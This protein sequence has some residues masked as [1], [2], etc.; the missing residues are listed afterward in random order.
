MFSLSP[1]FGAVKL[2][3]LVRR[4]VWL[5]PAAVLATSHAQ[6]TYST[7]Y[8]FTHLAGPLGG[9]GNIDGVGTAARFYAPMSLA[10]DG[11]GN[12]YVADVLNFAIRKVT[13][14]GKVTTLD[15]SGGI[16]SSSIRGYVAGVAVDS[17]NNVYITDVDSGQ[18]LRWTTTGFF[19]PVVDA[20]PGRLA[21][22][23]TGTTYIA[24]DVDN[25]VLKIVPGASATV[26]AGTPS[27]Y[28]SADGAGAAAR[29]LSVR[30]VAVDGTGTLYVADSSN[31]TIRKITPAGDVTTFSGIAGQPGSLDGAGTAARFND[32][33]GLAVDDG[34]NVYVADSFNDT[35]RKIS[36]AGDVTTLAGVA[37]QAGS[38]DGIGAAARFYGPSD[39]A[40]DHSGNVYVADV[41]NETI[42]KIAVDG[43]VG[44]L[45]GLAGGS[46]Y[47]E[48]QATF[49]RFNFSGG[50]P[51]HVGITADQSGTAYVSDTFNHCIRKISPDGK[52][53]ILAGSPG[54]AGS[55]DGSGS[56]ARF[57]Q[58]EGITID[59]AG[60]LFVTDTG[61]ST[62]RKITPDGVVTTVAGVPGDVGSTDGIGTAA[63]FDHPS[64]LSTGA[65]GE[66]FVTDTRNNS[67]R[68][69]SAGGA[70][71]TIA[72]KAGSG[73]FQTT[74]GDTYG[75]GGYRDG[76][77]ADA[78]FS[79]PSDITTDQT[80]N[81]Y[82][83]DSYTALVRKI[84]PEGVVTTVAGNVMLAP[85]SMDGPGTSAQFNEP[86]SLARDAV[87]NIYI[88][89]SGNDL[90]RRISADGNVSTIGGVHGMVSSADGMGRDALFNSPRGVAL[91]AAG[92][93]YVTDAGN[94]AVRKG[95]LAGAPAISVQPQ[96]Q[97]VRSGGSAQFAV[98]ADG[99]PPPAYQWFFGGKQIAGATNATFNLSSVA[100]GSAGDYTVVVTNSL[101]SVTSAKATLLIQSDQISA[102]PASDGAAGGG[103]FG[104]GFTLLLLTLGASYQPLRRRVAYSSRN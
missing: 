18:V 67:V 81:L 66:I 40:V 77:G 47:R 3:R 52:T 24:N 73:S 85:G 41:A 64:G 39:I 96:S 34:G 20:F 6:S 45:A 4:L 21:I 94:N 13:P 72:G 17:A 86:V 26:L 12:V 60:T 55:A 62:I 53:A 29:F 102:P 84:T 83:I 27:T 103:L 19:E 10:V 16:S 38:E 50:L 5:W 76:T 88:A 63:R 74:D 80:G 57:N 98:T 100:S 28:G 87:G 92:D 59:A 51:L 46:G 33:S 68:K 43:T 61:N 35:I 54:Q 49:A 95:R 44:T 101:G 79:Y 99:A 30:A 78:S 58:P 32:P 1:D 90:I 93:L 14:E 70:V 2:L 48:G 42:R 36:P 71:T 9:W 25:T 89:D 97:T 8:Y 56:A 82:V 15:P 104:P 31:D 69:I 23:K 75:P 22:D 11:A 7:P 65:T 37:G 91:D